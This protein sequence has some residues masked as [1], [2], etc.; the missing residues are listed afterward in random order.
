MTN[1]D[2]GSELTNAWMGTVALEYGWTG[3]AYQPPAV[4]TLDPA[5]LAPFPGSYRSQDGLSL[6]VRQS[7][8]GLVLLISSQPALSLLPRA[9]RRFF[10]PHLNL[11]VTFSAQNNL[12]LRQ[13][14]EDLTFNRMEQ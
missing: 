12:V 4:F 14:G 8:G 3:F 5:S 13:N 11:E 1:A 10:S 2:G 7:P 9:E 6:E